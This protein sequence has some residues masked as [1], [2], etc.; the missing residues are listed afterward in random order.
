MMLHDIYIYIIWGA[1]HCM[2]GISG[3]LI[4]NDH[5]YDDS[6]KSDWKISSFKR[7]QDPLNR[8]EDVFP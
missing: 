6:T 7:F 2:K 4:G 5:D 8:N 3:D 1:H